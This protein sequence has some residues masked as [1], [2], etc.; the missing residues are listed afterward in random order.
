MEARMRYEPIPSPGRDDIEELLA[1]GDLARLR[2][3]ALSISLHSEDPE[4][5]EEICL[6]LAR[7]ADG[8]TRGNAVL[9]L[10]HIARIH[11]KLA[12]GTASSTVEAALRDPDGW[13]RGQA[14][15]AA[16][17]IEQFLGWKIDR[18]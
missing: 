15:S 13:V 9:G 2:L 17:D 5:A 8:G 16:D 3:F 18:P 1:R 4:Q 10:G 14:T 7:H 11:R 6:R 12:E